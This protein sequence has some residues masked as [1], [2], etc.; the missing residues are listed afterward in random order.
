MTAPAT[1]QATTLQATTGQATTGQATTGQATA[2]PGPPPRTTRLRAFDPAA[3]GLVDRLVRLA[4]AGLPGM[5]HPDGLYC[6]TRTFPT[7]G[8]PPGPPVGRS[9]RY[10]AIVLLGVRHLDADRQR[11]A[12]GGRTADQVCDVLLHRLAGTG[13]VGDAAL[14]VWAAAALRHADLPRALERLDELDQRPGARFVVDLSWL[15]SGLVAA[16]GQVDV[17][18]RLARA[19]AR[20]LGSRTPGGVLFPHVTGPGLQPGYRDRYWAHL[21]CFADQ[22]YPVQALARLHAAADDPAALAAARACADRI[23]AAQGAAGQWWW[24][25]DAR[26]G[27]VVEGYP[28]YT[29]HQH[30]MAPMA[31]LDLA[32]AGGPRHDAALA[33]GLAWLTDRPEHAGPMIHDETGVTTR[34][35]ARR[36]PKKLV[37]GVRGASTGLRAG[38]RLGLLDRVFRPGAVD[39]ECRPYEFGWLLDCWLGGL[40][41]TAREPGA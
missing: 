41:R 29:V 32:E 25:Y 34:K 12:L 36:D 28:V 14:A 9:L 17:E 35:V 1:A 10:T 6:H 15:V 40:D 4:V 22:V 19:R 38:L 31:L 8:G 2:V 3:A 23:C 21:T 11:Q 37:R 16:R 33:R 24:H 13:S 7:P 27:G 18:A 39:P 30:A 5:Q 20:L 26:T